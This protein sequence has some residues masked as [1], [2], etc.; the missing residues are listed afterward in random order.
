M[1]KI[2]EVSDIYFRIY[3]DIINSYENKKRN[4][5]LLQN[6]RDMNKYNNDFIKDMN[7]ILEQK[8]ISDKFNEMITLYN[9][10]VPGKEIKDINTKKEVLNII[11]A[12]K[13]EIKETNE[14]KKDICL[15]CEMD[16]S[17]HKIIS[18]GGLLPNLKK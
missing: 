4:Y 5:S 1:N 3:Q 13:N 11:K 10:I 18:Y 17:E 14:E 9:K 15:S 16:H 12:E 7:N 6:I 2:I 8:N